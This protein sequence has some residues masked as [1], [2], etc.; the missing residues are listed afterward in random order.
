ML[1]LR[2]KVKGEVRKLSVH[3]ADD[4][5]GMTWAIQEV[6]ISEGDVGCADLDLPSDVLQ[7]SLLRKDKVTAPIDRHDGAMEAMM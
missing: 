2:R 7:N 4:A 1:D 5:H 3:G 6:G